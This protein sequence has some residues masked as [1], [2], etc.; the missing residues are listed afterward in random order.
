MIQYADEAPSLSLS[1]PP[2]SLSPSLRADGVCLAVSKVQ[3]SLSQVDTLESLLFYDDDDDDK[4]EVRGTGKKRGRER[5]SRA[6]AHAVLPY[7]ISQ[8]HVPNGGSTWSIPPETDEEE[9]AER[10]S[11]VR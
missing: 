11:D 6:R 8:Q 7:Q 10:A 5:E 9:A 3:L 2:L 4:D 1:P